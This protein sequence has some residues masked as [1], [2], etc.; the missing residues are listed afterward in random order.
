MKHRTL[1]KCLLGAHIAF[2]LSACYALQP[3][4][5]PLQVSTQIQAKSGSNV[6]GWVRFAP[7]GWGKVEVTAEIHGLSPGS[8]GFHVHEYGDCSAADGSSAGGHFNPTG[9]AHGSPE[10]NA[11]HMGDLG[12]IVADASGVARVQRRFDPLKLRGSKG[13]LGRAVVI[14]EKADDLQSQP[15]G[16][17]GKRVGCGVIAIQQKAS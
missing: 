10:A 7:D 15:S 4:E 16:A 17:A 13:I 9:V 3:A 14:H 2:V 8:H 12:N 5:E 6:K 11:H 1:L